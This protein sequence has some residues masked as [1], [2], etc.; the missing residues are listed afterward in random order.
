[1]RRVTEKYLTILRADA[2][3]AHLQSLKLTRFQLSSHGTEAPTA[4]IKAGNYSTAVRRRPLVQ[5]PFDP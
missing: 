5:K 1:M 3:K 4:W 2:M